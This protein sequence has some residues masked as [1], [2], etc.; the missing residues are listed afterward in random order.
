M[1]HVRIRRE[2]KS[3]P[4][5]VTTSVATSTSVSGSDA[6]GGVVL[7]SGV[8]ASAV[9]T[10]HGSTD[11]GLTF[12]AVYGADGAA[13]TLVVPDGGGVVSMPDAAY[14]LTIMR[15]VSGTDLGTAAAVAVT[16]KA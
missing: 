15:L 13:A 9:L 10:V 7:I 3:A 8:T 11:N 1:T 2:S 12:R 14:G 4:V 6:A 16:M 5:T